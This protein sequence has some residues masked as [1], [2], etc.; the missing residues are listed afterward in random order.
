MKNFF[1]ATLLFVSFCAVFVVSCST[2]TAE[3]DKTE[4]PVDTVFA[5]AG[6]QL[7]RSVELI[8]DSNRFPR[9]TNPDGVWETLDSSAWSSGFFPGCLWIM[10]EQSK[11]P[12]WKEYAVKWTESME[13]EKYC[14]SDHNNGFKMLPGF[15]NGYRLT[16]NE[17]YREVLIES[18]RSLASR[19]NDKVECIKANEM[20]QWKFPVMVDTMCN[21]ELLVWAAKNGGEQKWLDMAKNHTQKTMEHHIRRDGS[22]IQVIDFNPETGE[23]I[24][25]GTLC[26]LSGDSAWSRGQGQALYGFTVMYRETGNPQFLQTAVKLADYFIDNLPDDFVP[27]WDNSDPGI[28]DVIRDSS[29]AATACVGLIELSSQVKNTAARNKYHDAAVNILTSLV[30]PDYLAAA[31]DTYGIL[32]HATWKK[33]TD[34][35][36]DTSLIWGD[37]YFLVALMRMEQNN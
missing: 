25:H 30:S 14:T 23:E 34:P 15:G 21:L 29:A 7:T 12:K 8:K 35:Q 6:Q 2:D 32:K 3:I 9:Y 4:I 27:Y 11:D 19:Y 17:H 31:S 24:G 1:Y 28:P 18:A 5:F 36:A 20:E 13:K 22:T 33:P 37:Y 10:Y 16:G 26:G